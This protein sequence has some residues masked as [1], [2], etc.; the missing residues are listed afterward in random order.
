MKTIISKLHTFI[1][2]TANLIEFEENVRIYMYEVFASLLGGVFTNMNMVKVREKQAEGW[3]VERNDERE[4]QFTF[5]VVRFTHTLMHDLEGN[6]HYPFDEWI[7]F[8]KYQRRSPFVEV[9]VAEMAAESTYRET[10]RILKEWTAVDISHTTVGTIVKKVGEAQAKADEELVNEL[11]ESA[12]LPEGKEIDFLYAEADGVFVRGTEK[13]KSYEVSHAI[14]YE[15]W[16]RNGKR[17]SLRNPTAI[18]TTHPTDHFWKEVQA[19]TAYRYSLEKTQVVTNSDGG[20]GYTAEKFQEAFSQSEYPVLNQLDAYHVFQG[21]NR[22]IGSRDSKYKTELRK[23][24]KE[25]DLDHF[26]L[27]LNTYENTLDD[28]KRREKVREF[29]SYILNNWDRIVDWRECIDNPPEDARSLG[30]MESNHRYLTYRMKKRGMHWSRDGA[31]AMVKVKQGKLNGTLREVYL[32]D[33]YRGARKQREVKKAVRM[34][35]YLHQ[36][37]RPSIGLKQG[38]IRVNAP[39]SSPIGK[40]AKSFR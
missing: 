5:G 25:H 27:W 7:G 33:Q 9:K 21:L 34:S 20:T 36:P 24:I 12:E 6:A 3:T 14:L 29:R 28:A 39:H 31:E 38:S 26:N 30:A 11:E 22:A 8:R 15:G 40:L 35:A 23:A 18:M 32:K 19:L 37:T 2:Q 16:D 13:R 10:A 4:I 1:H 17:I